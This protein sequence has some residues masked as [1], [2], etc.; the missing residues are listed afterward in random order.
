MF[1]IPALIL[2]L[3]LLL[4]SAPVTA[5]IPAFATRDG[6]PSLAPLLEPVTPAVVNISVVSRS[7]E[8]NNPLARDPFFR[9]FFGLR[10]PEPQLSAGSGVIVSARNGHVVTNHH[11]IKD[12]TQVFVI[13][14]DN[15]RFLA[16]VIGSDA[17]TDVALLSIPPE[18]LTEAKLGDSDAMQVGDFVLAIGNPF[19]IGQ[20]VTSGIVSALGRSGLL[21]EGYEDFIQTDAS[22]NPGNSGGALINM[23]G[24]LVGINTAIIGPA[25]GNVG[26]GFAVP[27]NIVRYVMTQLMRFGEVKRGWL[28][29]SMQDLTPDL[30]KS[31]GVQSRSGA[32]IAQVAIDSPAAAAGLREGDVVVEVA[33]RAVRGSADL[34]NRLGLA[35]VGE[36]LEFRVFR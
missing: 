31:L 29:M 8:E 14:K 4:A 3:A 35:A 28:G 26:I 13:L 25:G 30:A 5:A 33:G 21:P 16:K 11:V 12:A 20:T 18:G 22:I 10:S 36:T 7:P 27:V 24:E 34:R 6:M 15:R 1:L 17:S 2:S 32:V 23:K 19:G 9:R